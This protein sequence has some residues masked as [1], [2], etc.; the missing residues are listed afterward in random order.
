M[1]PRPLQ[2]RHI[3]PWDVAC[4]AWQITGYA[5]EIFYVSSPLTRAVPLVMAVYLIY[6]GQ[7]MEADLDPGD[8]G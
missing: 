5:P 1:A 6:S 4:Q 2:K 8:A 7:Q 3:R